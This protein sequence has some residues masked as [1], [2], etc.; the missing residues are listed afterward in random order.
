MN[1][2]RHHVL[3]LCA[4]NA[5]RSIL[6][7]GL[8]NT[9]GGDRFVA[10]SAGLRPAPEIHRLT[11]E[12]LATHS[13]PIAGLRCKD[14]AAFTQPGAPRIDL[15]VT[16]CARTAAEVLPTLPGRPL[17]THWGIEDPTAYEGGDLETA[18]RMFRNTATVLRRR[19]E[20]LRAL[21][22]ES[23]DRL[24]MERA[25]EGIGSH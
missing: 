20:L 24:A 23:L 8:L 14:V 4:D 17:L 21:P 18:S 15:I 9:L 10:Y 11:L 7:E 2:K 25:I 19:I 12:T 16:V 3:F 1:P 5:N 22:V 13:V 6:A